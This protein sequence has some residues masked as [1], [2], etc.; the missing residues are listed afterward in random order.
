MSVNFL[1]SYPSTVIVRP[2]HQ[3]LNLLL[4][5]NQL[6]KKIQNNQ[7]TMMSQ[8]SRKLQKKRKKRLQSNQRLVLKLRIQLLSFQKSS[9][10][11]TNVMS[12]SEKLLSVRYAQTQTS[13]TS[14]RLT[15][16]KD[17]LEKSDLD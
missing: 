10:G 8:R 14:K 15:V 1:N 6:L 17:N 13:Y 3:V 9:Y 7:V 2:R 4:R 5:P 12:E 16:E 11:S